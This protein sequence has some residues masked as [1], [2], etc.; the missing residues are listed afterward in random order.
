MKTTETVTLPLFF[1][2]FSSGVAVLFSTTFCAEMQCRCF[3][4]V[5]IN[6]Q[7]F[8]CAV[9]FHRVIFV[10]S[11]CRY[12][13]DFVSFVKI[14][15]MQLQ[16]VLG[17]LRQRFVQKCNV[18]FSLQFSS[19]VNVFCAVI[20]R[21]VIFVCWL[22]SCSCDFVSFVKIFNMQLQGVLGIFQQ[23]FVQKCNVGVSLQFSS[24]FNVL[25]E[26]K[27]FTV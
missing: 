11:L 3:F 14:L 10:C 12:I 9:I 18:G 21:R 16:C 1:C 5:F 6:C 4:A 15:N 27:S 22:C 8:V 2:F 7:C 24:I 26:Q 23:R 17:I 19:I 13:C 25:F 20:F